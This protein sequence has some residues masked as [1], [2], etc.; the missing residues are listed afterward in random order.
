VPKIS[1]FGLA[2]K[3]DEVGQT[4][5]GQVMGTPSY[6]APEQAQGKNDIGPP[7]DLYAL[8][9]ILYETLTGRP[10]FKAATTLDTLFQVVHCEPV[11][12]RQL[13]PRVPR[14]LETVCLKCLR[15]DPRQRYADCRELADDLRRWLDGEPVRARPVGLVE[16]SLKWSRRK[17][18]QAAFA[19][20]SLF[21]VTLFVFAIWRE[22]HDYRLKY[23]RRIK[24][25]A[26]QSDR[27][28]DYFAARQ[29]MVERKWTEARSRLVGIQKGLEAVDDLR[30]DD[31]QGRVKQSLDDVNQHLQA[32][33]D[34]EQALAR[35][36][37][38][39]ERYRDA[40]FTQ[41][42]L[43]PMHDSRKNRDRTQTA[44]RPA[45]R[46]ALAIYGLD[47]VP[48]PPGRLV[49]R[50]DHDRPLLPAVD[51][52]WL[53]RAC[54]ELLLIWAEVEATDQLDRNEP[55][56]RAR[57]RGERALALL[58]RAALVGQA[59]QLRTQIY[60]IRKARFQ[61][62]GRDGNEPPPP[63]DPH[64][65]D[66]PTCALDWFF[67]GLE[68]YHQ[69]EQ[70]EE[71]ARAVKYLEASEA[72]TKAVRGQADHFWAHYLQGL[73][74][75]RRGRW[76]EASSALTVCIRLQPDF[77]WPLVLRGFAASEQGERFKA[78]AEQLVKKAFQQRRLLQE[79]DTIFGFLREMEMAFALAR[80]DLD[81]ALQEPQ[82][83][84]EARYVGLVNRG[85][86]FFR[87]KQWTS[88]ITDL[89]QAI[90]VN[91]SAFQ[92]HV[93]LAQA[94][95]AAGRRKEALAAISKAIDCAPNLPELYAIRA[96]MH[97]DQKDRTSARADFERAIAREPKTSKSRR[98]GATLVELG[99]LL[100]EEKRYA[101]A[102]TH[103]ERALRVR[104]DLILTE[105]FRATALLGLK[106]KDEAAAALDR[107]LALTPNP[108]P[109]TLQA[110]GLLHA[111][112]GQFR[113]AIELYSAV[114]RLDPR[115]TKTRRHRA[116]T[117]FQ[118]G[119]NRLALEDFDV[120]I[121]EQPD[122]ADH[123]DHLTGRA[124]AHVRLRQ[125]AEAIADAEAAEKHGPLTYRLCYHLSCAYA[126][127][128]TQTALEAGS[129][130]NR[131]AAQV[132]AR[133]AEKAGLL[134]KRALEQQP[135]KDRPG[136][137]REHV[138]KDPALTA[139]RGERLY[140]HLARKYGPEPHPR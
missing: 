26:Y 65:P 60:Y 1:D 136:F 46:P 79:N 58:E 28:K 19:L 83:D 107:Y 124:G 3:L 118:S 71:S 114:L 41:L 51:F 73:C 100:L 56:A 20:S 8:G 24:T 133:Y 52:A 115:D 96:R 63:V 74:Q 78:Q 117:F 47:F 64:A 109:E 22:A 34:R 129:G 123:A 11:P 139:I 111:E 88:A 53:S 90:R 101:V 43:P 17:P 82:L 67:R 122:S 72:L 86:L 84:P 140:S 105:R 66:E 138:A 80:A 103:F 99:R 106:R 31:L 131:R 87:Q 135:E 98:L 18:F 77:P 134:L 35:L 55:R 9:A 102:L 14:D 39:K 7:A 127:A 95:Q 110:R 10:P 45:L 116:W 76:H 108:V 48:T 40:V 112:K 27:E 13:N 54:Y 37:A 70:L 42:P 97:L 12:L 16:R 5:T 132:V 130:P 6:M 92:A 4:H 69:A 2:K 38:F 104:P 44:A 93:N 62:L 25:E 61:A 126:Q 33:R 119:S 32:D 120:C 30:A 36:K 49:E 15:K 68:C 137:W 91:S 113:E 50:L 89:K 81:K 121:R 59:Y 125:V 75:L 85:V 94:F 128:A 23:E 21:L 57:L 29:L